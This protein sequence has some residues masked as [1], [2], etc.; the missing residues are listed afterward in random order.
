MTNN[1]MREAFEKWAVDNTLNVSWRSGDEYLVADTAAAWRAWQAAQSVPVVG[2]IIFFA[3]DSTETADSQIRYDVC[4][5]KKDHSFFPVVRKP[6]TSIPA[7]ELASLRARLEQTE[8]ERDELRSA[9]LDAMAS[10][11]RFGADCHFESM[12]MV[13]ASVLEELAAIAQGKGE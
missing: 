8:K 1:T 3:S 13:G 2:D 6:T 11:E 4:A 10:Y 9:I 7:A 5:D 12:P